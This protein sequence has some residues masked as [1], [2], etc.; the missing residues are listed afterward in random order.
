VDV[1]FTAY[2]RLVDEWSG[3]E[4]APALV[5]VGTWRPDTPP[6]PPGVLVRHDVPHAEVMAAW[7]GAA[8]GVVPSIMEAMGQVAV[9]ALLARTPLIAS[10]TGGLID[11]IRDGESGLH[12]PPGD[13][14]A[15]C[16]AL[17]RVLTDDALADRLR[18]AGYHR[19]LDFTAARVVPQI[20]EVYRACVA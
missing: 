13:A 4:P 10:R 18:T 15:L 11:M 2:R 12:V 20:E 17:S 7:H 5:C 6:V 14:S 3:G 19:G 9:E 1:L 8:A 16:A